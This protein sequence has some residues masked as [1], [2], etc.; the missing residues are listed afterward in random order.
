MQRRTELQPDE[1]EREAKRR[2][3]V[4]FSPT[5]LPFAPLPLLTPNSPY[6]RVRTLLTSTTEMDEDAPPLR[7]QTLFFPQSFD[8]TASV[9]VPET[10]AVAA[11]GGEQV[12]GGDS[13][14]LGTDIAGLVRR[15]CA[16]L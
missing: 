6:L 3:K 13:F 11:D 7:M 12:I 16:D 8:T 9:E 15:I 5:S 2:R 10:A 14:D 1:H 4:R